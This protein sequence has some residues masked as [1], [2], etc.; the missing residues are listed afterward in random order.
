MPV[1]APVVAPPWSWTGFYVG[2]H[3]GGALNM[4]DIADP[5]GVPLFGDQVRSPAFIGGGQVGY[6]YQWGSTVLGLEGDVSGVV[7]DGTNTCFAVSGFTVSSNCQVRPDLYATLTGRLGY[8]LGRTLLYAKGGAAWNDGTVDMFFNQNPAGVHTSSSH[9]GTTGWTL[10]A[11]I[12]YAL[13]PA[14]S[15]TLEYDYLDFGGQNVATPYVA[16]NPYGT[17][18]TTSISQ[19]VHEAK[20]GLNYRFGADGEAWPGPA[21]LPFK[22]PTLATISN[23]EIE[24]G[25]RYMYSWGRFQKDHDSGFADGSSVPNGIVTSRLTYDNLQTNSSELFAR[26][27][28]PWN[29]FIKGYVGIG[30]TG[31]G[32]QTDEDSFVLLNGTRAPYSNW[33]SDKINGNI[34]YGVADLG[35]DFLR[36]DAYK[37][38][39]FVGFS[40]FDQVMNRYNCVQIAN[41]KGSCEPPDEPPSPANVVRFQEL[42]NWHALSVGASWDAM[43]TD[44]LKLSAEAAYLPYLT[45]A[46]LD[47]H[48]RMPIAQ[49]PASSNGGHGVQAEALLS[50]YLTDRFSVG[51]GARYWAMWTTNGQ[52]TSSTDPGPPR[53]YRAAFEQAG[54]FLQTSYKFGGENASTSAA[55][56]A[57]FKEP[58]PAPRYNWTGLHIGVEGGGDWGRSK[59]VAS[60]NDIT[61]EYKVSGALVGATLGYDAQFASIWLFGMEGDMSWLSASGS[62]QNQP[63]FATVSRS[64]TKEPWL[65]TARMRL[66]ILATDRWLTY[67]TGGVALT[68]VEADAINPN[69]TFSESHIR[70]GWTAGAGEEVAI[71]KNWSAKLE[72]L[73]VGLNDTPYFTPPPSPNVA[74]RGGGVPLSDEIVRLGINYKFN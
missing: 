51:L 15:A 65:G 62:A 5:F 53:Y 68:A 32:N 57:V 1:K 66:G 70:G 26:I 71:D 19:H 72:Y 21:S 14:W 10:G 40:F 12:E 43:L 27:D 67:V 33:I 24:G 45:F 17:A 38:G 59:H 73:H 20:L 54:V 4:T 9:F 52:F 34:D 60:S 18:P 37:V 31:S 25:A 16:G 22:W 58:L 13:T 8:S 44:R 36:T 50:Y 35:Y 69:A 46:G 64:A 28:S 41:P 63:P 23:W 3:M 2:G 49:F 48:F 6:N 42:D 29:V 30:E 47:N 56:L 55:A 39:A 61:P 7:S 74:N 11:G